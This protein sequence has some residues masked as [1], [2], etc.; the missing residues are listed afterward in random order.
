MR[1]FGF[2]LIALLGVANLVSSRYLISRAAISL[3]SSIFLVGG[4]RRRP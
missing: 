4:A 2:M 3:L 1:I